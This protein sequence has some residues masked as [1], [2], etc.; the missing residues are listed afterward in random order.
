MKKKKKV[1]VIANGSRTAKELRKL[2]G[3][4]FTELGSLRSIIGFKKQKR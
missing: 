3:S 2:V 4:D 1:K